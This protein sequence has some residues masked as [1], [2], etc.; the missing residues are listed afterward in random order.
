[1]TSLCFCR[2]QS[3]YEHIVDDELV[4]PV[5]QQCQKQP[6]PA[7]CAPHHLLTVTYYKIFP[8]SATALVV[9]YKDNKTGPGPPDI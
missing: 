1:M 3:K 2:V 6:P 5:L 9:P 8:F 7:M 4:N